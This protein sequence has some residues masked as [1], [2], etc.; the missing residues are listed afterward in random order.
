MY[1]EPVDQDGASADRLP[2]ALVE[3]GRLAALTASLGRSAR[4][5]GVAAVASG[6]WLAETV[7]D[8][9]SH[10]AL[11]NRSELQAHFPGLSDD[12]LA[13]VLVRNAARSAAAV[14]AA[15]GALIG[16]EELV[17][18][19]WVAIPFEL[20]AETVAIAA[21]EMKLIGE[22]HEVY[23]Q[24]VP[25]SPLERGYALARAW[26]D[27][28]SV[29]GAVLLEGVP[30]IAAL[31]RGTR[32][33]LIRQV[34]RRAARRTGRNLVSLGP[35]MIGGALGAALNRRSTNR[36]GDT[37]IAALRAGDAAR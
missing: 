30:G 33:Q 24:P 19:G 29:T 26:A 11:R 10:V 1:H 37:V 36:L 25:G 16:A 21:I 7:L 14:G 13:G 34:R 18:P 22:L 5:A 4:E 23:H 8:L 15:S 32:N 17:P 27:Q 35:L 9:A 2:A 6:H 3:G 28:R 31:G 20:L 12:T